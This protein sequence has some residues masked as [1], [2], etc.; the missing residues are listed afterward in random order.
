MKKLTVFLKEHLCWGLTITSWGSYLLLII[1]GQDQVGLSITILATLPVVVTSW[2]FGLIGSILAVVVA[3]T[4]NAILLITIFE[5]SLLS[6]LTTPTLLSGDAMLLLVAF[7]VG[8]LSSQNRQLEQDVVKHRNAEELEVLYK[9][10]QALTQQL[11]INHVLDETYKGVTRLLD[12]SNFYIALLD[13]DKAQVNFPVNITSSAE[14]LRINVLNDDEGLTGHILQTKA[15]ILIKEDPLAWQK[16]NNVKIVGEIPQSW[17]GVPLLI[18][19]NVI[20]VLTIYD[21]INSNSYA[22]HDLEIMTAIASQAAVAIQNAHLLEKAE[23]HA[24]ELSVLNELAQTLTQQLDTDRILNETYKGVKRLI[25]TK[26]ISIALLNSDKTKVTFPLRESS[27][28]EDLKHLELAPNEGLTG[29]IIQTKAPILINNNF[30]KWEKEHGVKT[31]GEM[32]QSWLGVPLITGEE[33]IGV[34]AIQDFKNQHVYGEHDLEMM[35]AIASQ[36]AIALENA[37]LFN[38]VKRLAAL[39]ELTGINNR[40][41]FL[42]LAHFEFKCGL[43]YERPLSIMMLDIDKFKDFNDTYG[44]AIGDTV[45]QVVSKI[46]TQS[47]RNT[48]ILARYGGEEFVI[49]LPETHMEIVG[50][51]AERLRKSVAETMIPTEG[52]DLSVTV[53]IGI[54]EKS[55]LTPTLEMLIARADQA[56]YVAKHKGRNQVASSI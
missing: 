37:R 34:L 7:V 49:L 12:P 50:T 15:P 51:L 46:C 36:A 8:R 17:L 42:E 35:T 9:L 18:G 13:S 14:D 1:V 5:Y 31:I 30:E 11:D 4:I 23:L 20:G 55:E 52:G 19:N 40:R 48:D 41:H 22:E 38:K 26:D 39:D 24:K 43:R 53:S 28:E 47:L 3:L 21:Y 29:H 54:A 25:D 32:P 6:A 16:D 45:L 10:S 27:S 44:H 33:T 2:Y 56:M